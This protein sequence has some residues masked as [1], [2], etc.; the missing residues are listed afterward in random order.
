MADSSN[1]GSASAAALAGTEAE[2]QQRGGNMNGAVDEPRVDEHGQ[3]VDE[4][5]EVISGTVDESQPFAGAAA[6]LPTT[7]PELRAPPAFPQTR[8]APGEGFGRPRHPLRPWRGV[9]P[10]L[11]HTRA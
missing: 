6:E 9:P 1:T 10:I 3:P 2:F 11:P 7:R 8:S 5:A 4:A